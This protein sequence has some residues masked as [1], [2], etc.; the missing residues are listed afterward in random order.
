MREQEELLDG[1]RKVEEQ[2][3]EYLKNNDHSMVYS[4]DL[5]LQILKDELIKNLMGRIE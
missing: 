3:E 5:T 2:K 1:I 4:C